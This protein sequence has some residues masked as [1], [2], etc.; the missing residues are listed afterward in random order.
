M[1][2]FRKLINYFFVFIVCGCASISP[3]EGGEKDIKSPELVS[4]SPTNKSL[5]VSGKSITLRF[6]EEIRLKDFNRQLIISPSTENQIISEVDREEVKLSFEKNFEPN[7][8]YF[9][10]FREGIEDI[11]E[12][13]K[14]KN[15]TL[16]FS[17]GAFLDSGQVQGV[18]TD[19]LTST[20][21]KDINVVL[22]AVNDTATIRK[23]KPYY[24]TKTGEDGTYLLQNI[25]YGT[26]YLYAHHDKNNDNI[27]NDENEKIG[28]LANPIEITAQTPPQ[29]LQLVRIDTKA[30]YITSKQ[31]YLDE[32]HL[33][34]NEGITAVKIAGGDSTDL[35]SLISENTKTVRL[36]PNTNQIKGKYFITALDSAENAKVDTVDIVFSGKKARRDLNFQVIP[37]T[38]QVKG[39]EA[40]QL[41]FDAPLR[42]NKGPVV[43]LVEDSVTNRVLNYPEDVKLN[44]SKNILNFSLNSKAKKTIDILIDTTVLIPV[45]GDRFKKQKV[46]LLVADKDQGGTIDLKINTN[47][48]KYFLE[49]LDKDYKI[50]KTYDTPK[51]LVLA[52]L[53][54]SSYRIRV[55]ID[56]DQN[57]EWRAGNQDLKTIPEKVINQP[58]PI[59]VRINW[60]QD[61]PFEF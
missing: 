12:G 19:L 38:N 45:S 29:D 6:N 50:L 30:P 34:Y 27:Y 44:K 7:T 5:Q 48:K 13:N 32:Y 14:P 22:Y 41:K 9:L 18:V 8:T 35:Y 46:S 61:V 33:N 42:L 49:L 59:E 39:N 31:P 36:F 53:E 3:P 40:L 57:G 23:N 47:Y 2:D 17:T 56:E 54:P 16:T 60:V 4:S 37:K 15:L 24:L 20:P 21:A 1:S 28:Y 51:S 43:T 52:E 55:K 58:K 26:Y 10:N 11:T 25:K